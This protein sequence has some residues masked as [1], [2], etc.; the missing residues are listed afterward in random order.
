MKPETYHENGRN[1]TGHFKKIKIGFTIPEL[2]VVTGIIILLTALVAPFWRSGQQ[3]LAL[4][5]AVHKAGQDV[6]RAQELALRAQAY[7]CDKGSI[8]GYGVFFNQASP[9]SYILFAECDSAN[10]GYDQEDDTVVETIQLQN[11]IEIASVSTGQASIVFVPPAPLVFLKPGD[12]SAVQVSFNR[13]DGAGVPKVLDVSSKGV[14][15]ID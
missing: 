3:G 9:S 10:V 2:L 12:P 14:I 7:S 13:T 8:Y 6:R 4:D 15:D 1:G 5:R 11:G